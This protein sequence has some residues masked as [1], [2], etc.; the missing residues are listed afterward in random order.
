M[1]C[2]LCFI[3]CALLLAAEY[4]E[5]PIPMKNIRPFSVGVSTETIITT[6]KIIIKTPS[7]I[8]PSFY[9]VFPNQVDCH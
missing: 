4:W 9:G 5:P 3:L 2:L 7:N 6:G 8:S 1:K